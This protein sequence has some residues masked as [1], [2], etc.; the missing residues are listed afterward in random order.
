MKTKTVYVVQSNW[1][2]SWFDCGHYKSLASAEDFIVGF[3]GKC[4]FRIIKRTD[5]VVYE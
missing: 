3:V 1:G 4:K 2:I 5:E